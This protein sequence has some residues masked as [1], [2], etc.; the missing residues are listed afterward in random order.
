M[1]ALSTAGIVGLGILLVVLIVAFLAV[2]R[3]ARS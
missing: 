3:K 1:L 2:W